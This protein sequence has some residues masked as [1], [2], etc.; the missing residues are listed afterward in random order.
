MDTTDVSMDPILAEDPKL[1]AMAPAAEREDALYVGGLGRVGRRGRR[2]ALVER[3]PETEEGRR[4]VVVL[5][6]VHVD[7]AGRPGFDEGV[8][9][10]D[11]HV[12]LVAVSGSSAV[13][14]VYVRRHRELVIVSGSSAVEK[15]STGEE[16]K[17]TGTAIEDLAEQH[18]G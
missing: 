12:G 9:A 8:E 7:R 18:K 1:T 16:V 14:G 13:E 11:V 2:A 4:V 3:A 10:Q 15:A 5:H 17:R 6:G